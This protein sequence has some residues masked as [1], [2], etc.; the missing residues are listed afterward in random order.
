MI[1]KLHRLQNIT[2]PSIQLLIMWQAKQSI[3]Y[4]KFL[5]CKA[6][7]FLSY[8]TV[9]IWDW[10]QEWFR[11][12][13]NFTIMNKYWSNIL[14]A[15]P[16][17]CHGML[18]LHIKQPLSVLSQLNTKAEIKTS[19]TFVNLYNEIQHRIC[20]ALPSF[21]IFILIKLDEY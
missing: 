11:F 18:H 20:S 17:L 14:P 9:P 4:K 10:Q 13:H 2:Q 12:Q 7:Y 21:S 8:G 1:N 15:Y 3:E 6:W 5:A 19:S 16:N